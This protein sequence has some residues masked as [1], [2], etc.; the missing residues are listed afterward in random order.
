M[1]FGFE[2]ALLLSAAII[3]RFLSQ[4]VSAQN[5]P[6]AIH[7]YLSV[8]SWTSAIASGSCIKNPDLAYTPFLLVEEQTRVRQPVAVVDA[9]AQAIAQLDRARG[10]TDATFTT[11][12]TAIICNA[13]YPRMTFGMQTLQF[14]GN[15]GLAAV[16]RYDTSVPGASALGVGVRQFNS[17]LADSSISISIS[18]TDYISV[19]SENYNMAGDL[20]DPFLMDCGIDETTF[21]SGAFADD[22]GATGTAAATTVAIGQ[23]RYRTTIWINLN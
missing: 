19:C 14:R 6:D 2:H 5:G 9:C 11:N 13:E 15:G 20:A 10:R 21:D 7:A 17:P 1:C 22:L 4:P 18:R 12:A 3:T 8:P 16:V 23:D